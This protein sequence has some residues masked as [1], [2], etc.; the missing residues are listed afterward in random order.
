MVPMTG[1]VLLFA[2]TDDLGDFW[3]AVVVIDRSFFGKISFGVVRRIDLCDTCQS[4]RCGKLVLLLLSGA[5]VLDGA[6]YFLFLMVLWTYHCL[7]GGDLFVCQVLGYLSHC[8][9]YQLEHDRP[10]PGGLLVCGEA[11]DKP[12]GGTIDEN[13][14][15]IKAI[16]AAA[17]TDPSVGILFVNRAVQPAMSD[18]ERNVAK[19]NAGDVR[20]TDAVVQQY[21]R[22][23]DL[24]VVLQAT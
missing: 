7:S 23:I 2:F 19:L 15:L 10:F 6:R 4:C 14:H 3:C 11:T 20:R 24:D 17:I 21:S 12:G 13:K 5:G 9:L 18:I 8:K 1:D 22:H 16:R